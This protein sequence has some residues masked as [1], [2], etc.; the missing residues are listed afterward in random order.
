MRPLNLRVAL[1][2]LVVGVAASDVAVADALLLDPD[3]E[4]IIG[5][6]DVAVADDGSSVVVWSSQVAEGAQPLN[7]I[8][9][10]RFDATGAA[11][12]EMFRIDVLP[13]DLA[14]KPSVDIAPDGSRF[15]V[16]WEGGA[17]GRRTRRR[18]WARVFDS[19]GV[20]LGVD[21]RVDQHRM[22][23]EQWG[24][25]RGYYRDPRVSMAP[26]GEFVVVWRSEGATSC[27]RF[28]ISARRFS[29]I[30]RPLGD[31]FVVNS[32]RRWSQLNPDVDH[33]AAGGFVVVW[34]SGRYI[35]TEWDESSIRARSF[36][37]AGNPG[38]DEIKLSSSPLFAGQAGSLPSVVVASDGAFACA[39]KAGRADRQLERIG[40]QAFDSGGAPYGRAVL[41]E[42]DPPGEG[43]P[44]LSLVRQT[45]L[46][47][48][49]NGV[50]GDRAA[51]PAVLAQI[52]KPSGVVTTDPFALS[53]ATCWTVESPSV[54]VSQGIGSVV[55]KISLAQRVVLRRFASAAPWTAAPTQGGGRTFDELVASA[56]SIMMDPAETEPRRLG[57]IGFLTCMRSE[58]GSAA[59]GFRDLITDDDADAYREGCAFG[60][61]S[62][63]ATVEEALPTLLGLMNDIGAA[64]ADR[65]AAACAVGTLGEDAISAKADLMAA[66]EDDDELVRGCAG[67][68]LGQ[69]G[70]FE[71]VGAIAGALSSGPQT[72]DLPGL[73][74]RLMRGLA[75]MPESDAVR[76][77]FSRYGLACEWLTR[78]V[79]RDN[80]T[81]ALAEPDGLERYA[82]YYGLR[83]RSLDSVGVDYLVQSVLECADSGLVGDCGGF[84]IPGGGVTSIDGIVSRYDAVRSLGEMQPCD[85]L[86]VL[87]RGL[88]AIEPMP[89]WAGSRFSELLRR[90][91]TRTCFLEML[92]LIETAGPNDDSISSV[93]VGLL[94]SDHNLV[95]PLLRALAA[96]DPGCEQCRVEIRRRLWDSDPGIVEVAIRALVEGGPG[97][98]LGSRLRLQELLVHD[99][100][101]VREA[102]ETALNLIETDA[103]ACAE[104]LETRVSA[105]PDPELALRGQFVRSESGWGDGG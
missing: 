94:Q 8:R 100:E 12:G 95:I 77:T 101:G 7:G 71:A 30:G 70:A 62:A 59:D 53:P 31:E 85:C 102:A 47:V 52:V 84:E 68:A 14:R 39:W 76:R 86:M 105:T 34:Q 81:S 25:P 40:V 49:W 29:P 15:V 63:A 96:T 41:I 20:P 69:I 27:D 73:H 10:R 61:A 88:S 60:L 37:S 103:G 58:A 45:E 92:E 32:I 97:S 57:A 50:A 3:E 36:D 79:D 91:V 28:N 33:D 82:R 99:A 22:T 46:M 90:A 89:D 13:G 55:W 38:G 93:L 26:N 5:E 43:G 23:H 65:A 56:R 17:Q 54:S 2:V 75:E 24:L 44:Q 21:F 16:A 80:R 6:L 35:G 11:V 104:S 42:P 19:A 67:E 51:S 74:L 98:I 66:L 48:A 64:N 9:I 4:R 18:V 83:F 72:D 78:Y 1:A 87:A